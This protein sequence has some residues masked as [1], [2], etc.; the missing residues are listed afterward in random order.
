MYLKPIVY[1]NPIIPLSDLRESVECH[2]RNITQFMLSITV[3]YE[4]LRFQVVA[5][6]GGH[7]IEHV[8]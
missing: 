3:E 7:H 4:I 5:D 8:L 6:N 2:V 1:H